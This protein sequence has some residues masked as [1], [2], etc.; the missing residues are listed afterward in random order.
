MFSPR[1]SNPRGK[2]LHNRVFTGDAVADDV[3]MG[4]NT[5]LSASSAS[6]PHPSIKVES[7]RC[8]AH[9]GSAI[10]YRRRPFARVNSRFRATLSPTF[11]QALQ[12]SHLRKAF[13]LMDHVCQPTPRPWCHGLS[14][15][16]V[17]HCPT[18]RVEFTGRRAVNEL[19]ADPHPSR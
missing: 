17:C 8:V 11:M 1:R 14:Q 6:Q 16:S 3:V 13:K 15:M 2:P 10:T 5:V 7:L 19:A 4:Q 18:A 9:Q 12:V